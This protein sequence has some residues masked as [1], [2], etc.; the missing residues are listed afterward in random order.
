[1]P[2][3]KK[4]KTASALQRACENYFKSISRTVPVE[5]EF[6]TGKK[7]EWGH[8]IYELRPV[9]NDSDV[10]I[11]R[12]EYAV[13]PSITGLCLF[14]GISR[15]TW[16]RYIGEDEEWAAVGSWSKSIIRDYLERELM[17]RKKG[18]QGV[19]FNLQNNY[20]EGEPVTVGSS[21]VASS[22]STDEKIEFIRRV[23]ER[24]ESLE[25]DNDE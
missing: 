25:N 12:T 23:A 5:E 24:I 2:K 17:T 18:I 9:K 21:S 3:E 6:N 7:D 20:S 16:R 11:K 10:V 1:M 8:F 19:I 15:E 14:L 4:Y 13:P 22:L